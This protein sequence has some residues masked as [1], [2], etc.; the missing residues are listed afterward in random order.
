M[1]AQ[2]VSLHTPTLGR[3]LASTLDELA[4]RSSRELGELFAAGGAGSLEQIAGHPR[5]RMLAVPGFGGP[6]VGGFLR[7]FAG[8]PL[9]LWEGKS[10][11]LAPSGA[12]PPSASGRGYNRVHWFG[13]R[14]AFP[15]RTFTAAS[16]VDAQ[17][18]LA[19]AYDVPENPRFVQ[20]TYDE[21]RSL[22]NGLFLGR[23]MRRRSAR[24]PQLLVWFALD[25]R[26]Q[27]SE[28]R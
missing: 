9:Q 1:E 17:P 26:H 4:S 24:S 15:F 12:N 19:I 28:P 7:W 22:G 27:D 16:I 23:G 3:A 8:S 18:C 5:G 11:T 21:L 13:H 10:F 20:S 14:R 25:T 6:V 2:Q